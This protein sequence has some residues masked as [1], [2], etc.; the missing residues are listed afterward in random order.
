MGRKTL[1]LLILALAIPGA[2]LAA[3][4]STHTSR[5]KAAPTVMYVLKGTLWNYTAASSTAAGSI[6][7]HVT[8]SNYHGRALRNTDVTFGVSADTATTLNGATTISNGAR[9]IVKFRALKNMT[10]S[11]LLTALST[12]NMTAFQVIAR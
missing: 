8:H 6:T 4:P 12:T 3:K 9:G 2:A 7:I 5:S 11:G 1:A 10:S